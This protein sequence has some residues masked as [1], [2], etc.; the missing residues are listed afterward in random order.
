M[1]ANETVPGGTLDHSSFGETNF[2]TAKVNLSGMTPPSVKSGVV[3]VSPGSAGGLGDAAL[4]WAAAIP[5]HAINKYVSILAC[6]IVVLQG[7]PSVSVAGQR[8]QRGV[9][10][11]THGV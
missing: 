4:L 8:L 9:D 11:V 6:V 3:N 5:A 10:H 7:Y 2:L 1:S